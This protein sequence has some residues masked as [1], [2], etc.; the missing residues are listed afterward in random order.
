MK[1]N[2]NSVWTVVGCCCCSTK[3]YIECRAG[4]MNDFIKWKTQQQTK[5]TGWQFRIHYILR[6]IFTVQC[7]AL[8]LLFLFFV[9]PIFNIYWFVYFFHLYFRSYWNIHSYYS[10]IQFC[11]DFW[12]SIFLAM[13]IER[14]PVGDTDC[15]IRVSNAFVQING[16]SK[17]AIIFNQFLWR[18]HKLC[19][20]LFF[21]FCVEGHNGINLIPIDPLHIPSISIKQGAESPVNIELK[22]SDV[23]LIGLS[24]CRFHKLR[25][26]DKNKMWL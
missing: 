19:F 8:L 18:F 10:I 16:E 23:D 21:C 25:Y 26:T 20:S 14:C 17:F 24:N 4:R 13:D 2:V 3:C 9:T 6:S 1:L 7:I 22:F 11:D 5:Q 15:I 12:F